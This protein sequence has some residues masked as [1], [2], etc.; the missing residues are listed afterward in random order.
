MLPQMMSSEY[1]ISSSL[2]LL[3]A[4]SGTAA[5]GMSYFA[6]TQERSAEPVRKRSGILAGRRIAN[7]LLTVAY[8]AMAGGLF[9]LWV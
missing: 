2:F 9:G 5:L 8:L 1:Q 7:V 6:Q 4:L 3:G